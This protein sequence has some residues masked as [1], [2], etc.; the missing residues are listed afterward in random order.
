MRMRVFSMLPLAGLLFACGTNAPTPEAAQESVGAHSAL[1]LNEIGT[2]D[3]GWP[4]LPSR[5]VAV[6]ALL[7]PHLNGAERLRIDVRISIP[8]GTLLETWPPPT[9][10][11]AQAAEWRGVTIERGT[12]ASPRIP[13]SADELI[14]TASNATRREGDA[15]EPVDPT[16]ACM[17]VNGAETQ[18]FA[19]RVSVSASALPYDVTP[20]DD[21]MTDVMPRAEFVATPDSIWLIDGPSE[22]LRI[23][24]YAWQP[25]SGQRH[26]LRGTEVGVDMGRDGTRVA[27]DLLD[28]SVSRAEAAIFTEAWSSALRNGALQRDLTAADTNWR[29]EI[30]YWVPQDAVGEFAAI[31]TEPA[32]AVHRGMLAR[33]RLG[34]REDRR[35]LGRPPGVTSSP[36]G[37]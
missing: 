4:P 37:Q 21:G 12:C 11:S 32:V 8:H 24:W 27:R 23:G 10:E 22:G 35:R 14:R 18:F 7:Y 34:R 33:L 19:Y 2:A 31:H 13:T 15:G 17:R 28:M 1:E 29:D 6:V 30:H 9:E 3:L 16:S 25:T 26:R 36:F 20:R 5:R